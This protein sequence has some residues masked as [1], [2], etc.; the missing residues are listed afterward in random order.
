V[1][2]ALKVRIKAEIVTNGPAGDPAGATAD[3]DVPPHS[4]D[5]L[6]ADPDT[7]VTTPATPM[8]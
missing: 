8:R 2:T 7:L 5:D 4:G 3:P 1:F 6:I